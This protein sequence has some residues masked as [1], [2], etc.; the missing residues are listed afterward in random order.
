MQVTGHI[1]G[2]IAPVNQVV[3]AT[4]ANKKSTAKP[5]APKV[6]AKASEVPLPLADTTKVVGQEASGPAQIN[7]LTA[8]PGTQAV[9]KLKFIQKG[10]NPRR[11]FDPV[12][13]EELTASVREHGLQQ[14]ILIRPIGD[15]FY[16][17]IA[18][19]RRYRATLEAFG[20]EFDM[21]VVIKDC[22]EF[23]AAVFAHIENTQ[24][25][26]MSDTEEAASAAK[27]V[28]L[29]KGDR[30]EAARV[31]SW[32]RTKLDSRLALMNCSESVRTARD[33]RK[34]KL[35]HAELFAT[36]S[37]DS[38]D[39][40]LP[41]VIERAL[42]I[43]ELKAL[44]EK[45]AAKLA[46][47]I[48]DK[49]ECA[50]CPHNSSVQRTMFETTVLD[51][52]CTN[53]ACYKAK[54]EAT[55]EST[56]ESLKEEYPVIRIVRAGD[57]FAQVKLR[58]DGPT[59]VGEMQAEACRGCAEFGAAVSALPEALGR[60]FKDQCFNTVCNQEKVAA[61]VRAEKA[62]LEAL[63]KAGS[64]ADKPK[65]ESDSASTSNVKTAP[66]E[67]KTTVSESDKVKAY[68]E[69]VWRSAMKKEIVLSY[70]RSIQYLIALA[71]TGNIR[72]V[73]QTGMTKVFEKLV[74][75]SK[76][77]DLQKVADQAQELTPDQMDTAMKMMAVSAMEAIPVNEL[78]R[79]TKH[80]KL[81][82]TKH[83]KMDADFLNLFTKSEI[84]VIA[85]SVNLD[86]ALGN[87]FTKLFAEK[88]DAI[89]VRLLSLKDF[90]YSAVIPAVLM[91]K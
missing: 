29:A 78:T 55:I 63:T 66:T 32:S 62:A 17:I 67:S 84:Q 52:S 16:K 74:G 33:E 81:D 40:L 18:G 69:N 21:H 24:R 14:P 5:R 47:A 88:K 6:A 57:N 27:I 83:W 26:D 31:L 82:L 65:A 13:M 68:R 72:H 46:T 53:G 23:E 79:L 76:A 15:G 10:N 59:G 20:E 8:S 41:A 7:Q 73:D 80:M 50:A 77:S 58:P 54:T 89:V 9:V 25:A 11:Y 3:E 12:E 90:D 85:K 28:G 75:T 38:Q 19:E 43:P 56:K 4:L 49:A 86:K 61:R 70:D 91:Y 30:E 64:S 36:L 87:N 2:N 44:I 60:V 35:G 37:K 34:I 22:T 51:G 45:A 42:S 48:F 71:V 1:Q 39:K